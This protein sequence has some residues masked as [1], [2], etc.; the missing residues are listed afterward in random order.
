MM[1]NAD[2][3]AAGEMGEKMDAAMMEKQ[4]KKEGDED[5]TD[6]GCCS[7]YSTCCKVTTGVIVGVLTGLL[8][9][10]IIYLCVRYDKDHNT[11]DKTK[12]GDEKYYDKDQK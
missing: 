7:E 8:I 11:V 5:K 6:E 4:D 10:F 3:M 2:A 1:D 12:E 9:G